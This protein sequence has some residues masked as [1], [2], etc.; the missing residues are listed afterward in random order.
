MI[1]DHEN[2]NLNFP[3]S[4]LPRIT[5]IYTDQ[6]NSPFSVFQRFSPC[7]CASVVKIAFPVTRDVGGSNFG[8]LFLARASPHVQ[9]VKLARWPMPQIPK[10]LM[11]LLSGHTAPCPR[12]SGACRISPAF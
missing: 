11:R 4:A 2:A 6:K 9:V 5:R 1:A 8:N 7:L 10:A 3:G 12:R